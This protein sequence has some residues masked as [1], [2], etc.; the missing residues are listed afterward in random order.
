MMVN[1]SAHGVD[2]PK[3]CYL[4]KRYP[5]LSQTFIVNEISALR[6]LGLDLVI[7]AS[8]DS[9][10]EIVHEKC[11]DLDVPIYYMPQLSEKALL[12]LSFRYH[13]EITANP[14]KHG[15]EHIKGSHTLSEYKTWV[16]V[17]MTAPLVRSLGV[18]HIHGHFATWGATA[19]SFM[20]DVTG[21]PFSFTAHARDIYHE[22]IDNGALATRI[23][24]ARFVITVSDFNK[25]YLDKLLL[26]QGKSGKVIRL[27][28]GMDLSRFGPG[29]EAKERGLIVSVGRFVKK[30]GFRY[31]IESCKL[32]KDK[33]KYFH[34]AIVG[35]GE[36]RESMEEMVERYG[37][38]QEVSF[39]GAQPQEDVIRI[40]KKAEVFALP[41]IV[42][43]DGDRDGLPTVLLE[44]M[45]LG[46]PVIST[47]IAGIPE[48]IQHEESG[49]LVPE[50]DAVSLAGA[51][52]RMLESVELREKCAVAALLSVEENFNMT[53][54]ART[55]REY[56][57][58]GGVVK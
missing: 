51:M 20:S 35:E 23:E 5:R 4:L 36:E 39:L 46:T 14:E 47:K 49:L 58:T 34:C 9:G 40:I 43:D 45:A 53:K 37:L 24:K 26:F 25:K 28:N 57:L 15:F 50:R 19:A 30:K 2:R 10:E 54:N 38:H 56:F 27:Y 12:E 13:K 6:S 32:L 52:G 48:M 3:V 29:G 31:L 18:T 16:Q 22:S 55:L 11:K 44:S 42:S 33:V 17:A 21:L 7:V 8:K 1:K 41:C